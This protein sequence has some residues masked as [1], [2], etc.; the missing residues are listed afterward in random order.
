MFSA[1]ALGT[2]EWAILP[3]P[4]RDFETA[5]DPSS[6]TGN[7]DPKPEPSIVVVAPS[8]RVQD[9]SRDKRQEES[10]HPA[11]GLW[12]EAESPA[13]TH[14]ELNDL[15]KLGHAKRFARGTV[16]A[17]KEDHAICIVVLG[18]RPSLARIHR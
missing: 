17:R 1:E 2:R 6:P 8:R 4:S 18:H 11:V 14:N 15:V 9:L 13:A 12:L 5:P 16:E 7:V 3:G 10:P